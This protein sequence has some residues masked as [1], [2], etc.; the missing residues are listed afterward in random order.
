MDTIRMRKQP[1]NVLK[2]FSHIS[3]VFWY[4]NFEIKVH[5]VQV[6]KLCFTDKNILRGF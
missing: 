2:I 1:R 5:F 6:A 3:V 4:N